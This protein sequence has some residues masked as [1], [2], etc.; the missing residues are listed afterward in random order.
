MTTAHTPGPWTV[1]PHGR[2]PD[3]EYGWTI[4]GSNGSDA[5]AIPY[6]GWHDRKTHERYEANAHLVAA[7]PDLLA[8][9]KEMDAVFVNVNGS[10]IDFAKTIELEGAMVGIRAAIA[11]AM[12]LIVP[13]PPA[14][15][16]QRRSSK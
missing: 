8:A 5:A 10:S 2:E 7:A 4:K 12:P 13:P 16:G 15:N 3:H 9:C 11:R 6:M 14:E 1:Q